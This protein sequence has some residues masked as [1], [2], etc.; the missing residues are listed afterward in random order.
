MERKRVSYQQTTRGLVPVYAQGVVEQDWGSYSETDH[1]TWSKLWQQIQPVL[2]GRACSSYLRHMN[3]LRFQNTIPHFQEINEQLSQATGWKIVAVD[4]LLSDG[5]FFTHLAHRQFPVSWWIRSSQQMDYLPEPDLFHDLVGHVPM[6]FEP[7]Y[8]KTVE[9]FGKK[10][11]SLLRIDP[12]LV[13][14]LS[15]L[16]WFTVEFGLVREKNQTRIMGAGILSSKGESEYCLDP[17]T[18]R[19]DLNIEKAIRTDYRID[20]YQDFYFV[21]ESLHQVY[22]AIDSMTA[23]HCREALQHPDPVEYWDEQ[24]LQKR[25]GLK[26]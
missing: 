10:A 19:Q 7:A 22:E 24:K 26:L 11:L 9:M 13:L 5:D 4:G 12:P 8:A 14:P 17:S 25:L 3:A 2:T 18:Y 16:Y 1:A 23:K 20:Q 6:L 21:S 15:R